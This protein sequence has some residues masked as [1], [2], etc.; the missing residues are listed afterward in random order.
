MTPSRT[1]N[2]EHCS[3]SERTWHAGAEGERSHEAANRGQPR[4]AAP[5]MPS[6][7]HVGHACC[8]CTTSLR[9]SIPLAVASFEAHTAVK[10]CA[11]GPSHDV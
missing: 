5:P 4:V 6:C 11:A 9:E 3:V 7:L 8:S 1:C 2:F 10:C